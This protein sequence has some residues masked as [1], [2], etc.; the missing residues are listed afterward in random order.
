[1]QFSLRTATV[2]AL[3]MQ[4]KTASVNNLDLL[5]AHLMR[6]KIAS[7]SRILIASYGV[8]STSDI[9]KIS[10]PHSQ[11][12]SIHDYHTSKYDPSHSKR[13]L[14]IKQNQ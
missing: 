14:I 9:Y 1:M 2:N 8:F 11:T 10:R 13:P 12:Q 6:T 4:F 3:L 5:R 7:V